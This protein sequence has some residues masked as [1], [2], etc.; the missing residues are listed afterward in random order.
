MQD[1]LRPPEGPCV[2]CI[3]LVYQSH[4]IETKGG[5]AN[6]H[7]KRKVS[8]EEVQQI[9]GIDIIQWSTPLPVIVLDLLDPLVKGE[10]YLCFHSVPAQMCPEGV[11]EVTLA[12]GRLKCHVVE[13][14]RSECPYSIVGDDLQ[15]LGNGIDGHHLLGKCY[16][17]IEHA[18][19]YVHYDQS[20]E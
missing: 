19:V 18:T 2:E 11:L 4:G 10:L 15:Q 17:R 8:G 16:R 3:S 7:G 1:Y 14:T 13:K 12:A 20:T 9:S 5:R 6:V